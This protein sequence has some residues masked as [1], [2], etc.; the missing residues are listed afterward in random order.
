[1]GTGRA[2]QSRVAPDNHLTDYEGIA[3]YS[4]K[5]LELS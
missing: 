1:M 3:L 4:S 2:D 5:N